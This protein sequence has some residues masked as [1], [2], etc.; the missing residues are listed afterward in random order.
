MENAKKLG[1]PKLS[2]VSI[3]IGYRLP[4]SEF[5]LLEKHAKQNNRKVAGETVR[6][7]RKYLRELGLVVE[8]AKP[9]ASG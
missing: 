5:K 1:R 3:A 4:L 2:E 7:V 9:P 6:A 8:K